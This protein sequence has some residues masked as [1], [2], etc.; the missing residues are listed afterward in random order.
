MLIGMTFWAR[1]QLHSDG[2][3][4]W[5]PLELRFCPSGSEAPI[6]PVRQVSKCRTALEKVQGLK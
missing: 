3:V 4:L 5:K 6:D 2:D 1:L